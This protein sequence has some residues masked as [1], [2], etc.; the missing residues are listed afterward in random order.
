MNM[1]RIFLPLSLS[2]LLV[3]C[4]PVCGQQT[5]PI[6]SAA[7]GEQTMSLTERLWRANYNPERLPA[8]LRD[9]AR[10][11][12]GRGQVLEA[13]AKSASDV[14]NPF[15]DYWMNILANETDDDVFALAVDGNNVY[16][17]GAFRYFVGFEANGI[18]LWNGTE[19]TPITEGGTIGVDGFVFAIAVSGSKV[20]VGGQFSRVGNV[21]AHNIAVWDKGT[22]TWSAMGEGITGDGSDIPFVSTIKVDGGNVYV[23]GQFTKAG[24][25]ATGN[26]ARWSNG[27]WFSVG[28]GIGV[29]GVV[30]T[31]EVFGEDLYV[32]GAFSGAGPVSSTGI[33][34]WDGS[35]WH[36]LAGGVVG[37]VNEI[38]ASGDTG[39]VVGGS[40]TVLTGEGTIGRNI[41]WW[42]GTWISRG[43][44][45]PFGMPGQEITIAGEVRSIVVDGRD[46]WVGG[47]FDDAHPREA[48]AGT[49]PLNNVVLFND[50]P[51]TWFRLPEGVNGPVNALAKTRHL[52]FAGGSFTR[53]GST[54]ANR[55][56]R[57][58][59]TQRRW[60]SVEPP[61]ALAPIRAMAF[62]KGTLYAAGSFEQ[63]EPGLFNAVNRLAELTTEGWKL[64]RG[65]IRG[66]IYSLASAG[67]ELVIGGSFIT[68][69]EQIT[70]NIARW[71][72]GTREWN[73]LTDGSGVASLNDVSFVTAILADG[74][75]MY[76]GGQFTVADTLIAR[77]IARWDRTTG[78]WSP[79]GEGVNGKVWTIAKD[80]QGGLYVGGEFTTSGDVTVNGVAYWNGSVWMPLG[81]GVDGIV[82]ALL[83]ADGKLYVGGT[84]RRAGSV[85][86]VNV[87]LWDPATQTWSPLGA[88]LHADFQPIVSVLAYNNGK[89]FA[90][91]KFERSGLDSLH[92]VAWWHPL[93]WWGSMGSGTDR[94]V[95]AM[96]VDEAR[97]RLYVGGDF[98]QAGCKNTPYTALWRDP[99]LSV[100]DGTAVAG[101]GMLAASR[102]NPFVS[103]SVARLIVPEGKSGPLSLTLCDPL[104]RT[105]RTLLLGTLEQGEH[106]VKIDGSD[107]PSGIYF[108]RLQ[109][110]AKIESLPL[111]R[112]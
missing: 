91:G 28:N 14:P 63:E 108:L 71:N 19:W 24:T 95:R 45:D 102:P 80:P 88:G 13:L 77:N 25:V 99:A 35:A 87:A 56:V 29:D 70:V 27:T 75:A 34:R 18:A 68:S 52:L 61:A 81:E 8:Q 76:L 42:S 11:P 101:S 39:I 16:A 33:I 43:G 2:L 44:D 82:N 31:L 3:L 21:E 46:L 79:V 83:F 94:T 112:Q 15:D 30:N 32:G 65:D 1:R 96:A 47:V 17:G 72:D 38:K 86:A 106:E 103:F 26:V 4:L 53:S 50:Q 23:G 60:L 9:V 40:F 66:N 98:L 10:A 85:E 58:D 69:D 110:G 49:G 51:A 37:Y 84:F 100:P 67:D 111:I 107:L 93:G 109:N 90:G 59:T 104:G 48:G 12:A 78:Q 22:K 36:D 7:D 92:N 64:I 41:A 5:G 57:W 20:Y 6:D 89:V 55:I 54:E 74:N 97:N 105:V 62:H 73:P